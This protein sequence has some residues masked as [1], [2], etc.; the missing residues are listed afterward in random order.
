MEEFTAG[1][2]EPVI[3]IDEEARM[4]EVLG[5]EEMELV[6]FGGCWDEIE[7]DMLCGLQPT[8]EQRISHYDKSVIGYKFSNIVN[9]KDLEFEYVIIPD[10]V[11]KIQSRNL[12]LLPTPAPVQRVIEVISECWK[13]VK[14]LG[15]M[16]LYREPVNMTDKQVELV[17]RELN[18][19]MD[20]EFSGW[21]R[22]AGFTVA[23]NFP[24]DMSIEDKRTIT[25]LI[26]EALYKYDPK[27]VLSEPEETVDGLGS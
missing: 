23:T 11:M 15:R 4:D 6:P 12:W 14:N 17:I 10:C 2:L 21:G 25:A 26:Q 19:V 9:C 3:I 16:P 1:F 22:A 20:G 13:Y 27:G 18:D 24:E 5:V 7:L 8:V